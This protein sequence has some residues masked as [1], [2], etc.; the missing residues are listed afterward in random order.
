[1]K[2]KNIAR[3][4]SI[5]STFVVVGLFTA[6]APANK[7]GASAGINSQLS[8]EGKIVQTGGTNIADGTYNMEFKI[9]QDGNNAGSGSTL[10][11]TE[12]WLVGGSGGVAL[13]SGTFQVNL[14]AHN[15]FG[16][17]VDWNQD[18]LWLS[19]QIGNSSSCTISTNFHT[20]CS[21]D[22]EMTPYIRLTSVP[23]AQQAQTANTL[24]G[25][26][27]GNFVQLAQRLQTDTS[28]TNAS[29]AINK[30]NS[31]GTPNILQLQKNS[32]NVMVIDN[33]GLITVQP[34]AAFTGSSTQSAISQTI[35]TNQ[36]GG[37]VNGFN[38]SITI[39]NSSGASTTNGFNISLSDTTTSLSNT[40][41]GISVN[42]TG[43]GLA[44]GTDYGIDST[45][46]RGVSIRGT[47]QG[48]NGNDTCASLSGTSI[49]VCGQ[50]TNT[51]SANGTGVVGGTTSFNSSLVSADDA[52]VIGISSGA[53]NANGQVA[54]GVKGY[55]NATNNTNSYTLAGVYGRAGT[56]S[57]GTAYGGAFEIFGSGSMSSSSA[58]LY[59]SNTLFSNN[60]MDLQDN[61]TDVFVVGDGGLIT[62]QPADSSGNQY[63]ISGQTEIAQTFTNHSST[64]GTVNGYSQTITVNN[65]SSATTTNGINIAITDATTLANTTS[66][67]Q[68][69]VTDNGAS[70]AKINKAIAGGAGGTNSN[71]INYGGYFSLSGGSSISAAIYGSNG[72]VA[73]NILDLQDNTTSVFTVGDGGL[74]TAT[75]N[76]A[77]GLVVKNSSS[78][79]TVLA[80]DTSA[81]K[82]VLGQAG[83]SG[84]DGTLVFNNSAGSNTVG[85][86]LQADP[87]SSYTLLL[88]TTGPST[89][90]CLQTDATTANQ[91]KF[92][93]C[94][95]GG[96]GA[97]SVSYSTSADSNGGSITS[98]VLTL[99]KADGTHPGLL[100]A[101]AQTIGGTKTFSGGSI[102]QTPSNP[103]YQGGANLTDSV[104]SVVVYNNY[105]YVAKNANGGTCSS[106][107]ATGCELQIYDISDPTNPAYVGGVD[108]LNAGTGSVDNFNALS[109]VGH[110]IYVAKSGD[111]GTC[112]SSTRDGCE[113]MI[114]DITSP[115]SPTYVGGVTSAGN[116]ANTALSAYGKYVFVVS[117][118][119]G[120]AKAYDVTN[121]ASPTT[122]AVAGGSIG[123]DSALGVFASG[124]YL[125]VTKAGDSGT[126]ASLG[127][128]TGCELTIADIGNLSS[129][130]AAGALDS[131]N[132]SNGT[133][134]LKSIFVSGKYLYVTQ[135]TGS[136]ATCS[137]STRDGCELQIYDISNPGS[138]TYKGGADSTTGAGTDGFNSVYVAG[139]Y[140]Y[141]GKAGNSGTCSNTDATGCE[142]QVWD[143]A[144]P[145]SPTYKGGV[146]NGGT[147]DADNSVYVSGRYAYIAK[148][149]NAGTCSNVN[150]TGCEIQ[151]VDLSGVEAV[152][153][154][155]GSMYA[156][157]MTIAN[158]G[159]VGGD[160]NIQ[161]SASIS[162]NLIV[163][164]GLSV[165]TATGTSMLNVD[166]AN[167]TIIFGTS[168]N[169]LVLTA[170]T[171]EP[172]LNGTARHQRNIKLM[173]EYPG[174]TM[175]GDGTNNT[176]TM[177]SDNANTSS[178]PAYMN[179]YDWTS[180][181]AG[182]DYSIWVRLPVPD[183]WA[184]WNGI[185]TIN[186]YTTSSTDDIALTIYDAGNVLAC[187][188]SDIASSSNWQSYSLCNYPADLAA[189]GWSGN[190]VMQFTLRANTSN[191]HV[192]IGDITIPYYSKW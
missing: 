134:S 131:V 159:Q 149:A 41:V 175:T 14:G 93:A 151:I 144:N 46:A 157:T 79:K 115:T 10:K 9:Y 168:T 167:A 139:H 172:A 111:S 86:S 179:Y 56:G 58:A 118:T 8:F 36:T 164:N 96:S 138:P 126:C 67:V 62:L 153:L 65:S 99:N 15:A 43:S 162:Q 97:T 182:N 77:S 110:Y 89:S 7:V 183:D 143:V 145:A 76:S 109:V 184:N 53:P 102:I 25:L 136:S 69:T 92:A 100:S 171:Y 108:S 91:L 141:I 121:P 186:A 66:G 94:S 61:I 101:D 19:L 116:A 112:S 55:A 12:D 1:V 24:A 52:G 170:S 4:L 60:I 120:L 173:A 192:R 87:V 13:S 31:S 30:N 137:S 103:V 85:F 78:S 80:V 125:Y 84:V 132:A 147:T 160:F 155:G 127:V 180:T 188:S 47:S 169:G 39:S 187:T 11:W 146:D 45:V 165:Q 161:G 128:L 51:G 156:G 22:S 124:R 29:I 42:L 174:A 95:A 33:G 35:T 32:T 122:I 27:A 140:A 130:S 37:A 185:G 50:S 75:S 166:S 148:V 64:G 18:T 73:A 49:G 28:T 38:Q 113:F 133:N 26:V 20:D 63:L 190:M 105:E 16:S 74:I 114:F 142:F 154:T 34:A 54:A 5:L 104:N 106:S 178:S 82:L 191:N 158:S 57:T 44:Y 40:K 177:T 6:L 17:Q 189:G 107:T 21:G 88:P 123:S 135:S 176:G 117:A 2:D 72:S 23:Y 48:F 90:Q 59:A 83:A 71:A 81:N 152:S 68:A 129:T 98:S 119:N 70:G 163:S 181:T 150:A 3:I